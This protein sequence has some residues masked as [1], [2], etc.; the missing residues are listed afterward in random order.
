MAIVSRFKTPIAIAVL[1]ILV[2]GAALF[3]QTIFAAHAAG[4]GIKLS[5]ISTPP[6]GSVKVS[7][8]RF[9]SSEMVTILFDTT[10]VGIATT[11]STGT[12]A[13]TITVPVSAQPGNHAVQA[14]GQASGLSALASFMVATNWSMFGFNPQ[15]THLNP[16]ENV[17]NTS[18]VSGLVLDWQAGF[19]VTSPPTIANGEIYVGTTCYYYCSNGTLTALDEKTG[20]SNLSWSF[21]AGYPIIGAP[22]VV[23]HM[24]YI[25][26][27]DGKVYALDTQS[28]ALKWSFTTQAT[29]ESSPVVVKGMIYFGSDDL[30]V[31]ALD[32]ITGALKW[33]YTTGS[34]VESSPAVANG[35]VY[36][37]SYDQKLYALDAKTGT[38]KWS[39]MTGNAIYGSPAVGNGMVYVGSQDFRIYALDA[40]RGTLKWTYTTRDQV[41]GS[42]AV[43]NGIVYV[44]SRDQNLYALDAITGVLK[45]SY[46]TG[47][48]Q[49]SP[50]IANG[51]VY[52]DFNALDA[53]SGS[54][55]WTDNQSAD[56]S[57]VVADGMLFTYTFTGG[58]YTYNIPAS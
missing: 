23:N 4:P 8:V 55:L 34:I 48:F 41:N 12:F 22:V 13:T 14:T 24:V 40:L 38:L 1:L 17:L 44:N 50:A 5:T 19:R 29:I 28:G 39:Y 18:N 2:G 58:I 25:S 45:W 46:N 16:Y 6:G 35:I 42:P 51:V 3:G 30:N 10:Q 49:A 53:Q 21:S 37:G 33:S 11:S 54:L 32:A 52:I 15:H 57:P 56:A 27:Q 26:S 7:G 36:V 31:Y 47:Y 43:A 9:G 20:K